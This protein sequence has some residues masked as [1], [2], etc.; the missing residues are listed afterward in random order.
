MINNNYICDTV[1]VHMGLIIGVNIHHHDSLQAIT[2]VLKL[3]RFG[4]KLRRSQKVIF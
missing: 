2:Q 3:C 4:L 1:A